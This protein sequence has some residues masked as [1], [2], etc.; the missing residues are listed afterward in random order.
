MMNIGYIHVLILLT[1]LIRINSYA[2]R[3]QIDLAGKGKSKKFDFFS[4]N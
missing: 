4:N 1:L 2:F 3:R